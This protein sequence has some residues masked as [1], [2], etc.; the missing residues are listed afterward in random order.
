MARDLGK[1]YT[2]FKCEAKF[3]DLRSP[4]AVCPKC[5]ADQREM[6]PKPSAAAERRRLR[7]KPAPEEEKVAGDD[8][9]LEVPAGHAE[10]AEEEKDEEDLEE[11]T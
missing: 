5:G 8:D 7:S 3:Y 1:K 11:E 4:T 2:C 10:D 9:E 6:P